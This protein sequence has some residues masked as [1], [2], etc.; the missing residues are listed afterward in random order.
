MAVLV[1]RGHWAAQNHTGTG[2]GVGK[3]AFGSRVPRFIVF[4]DFSGTDPHHCLF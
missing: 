3:L 4:A 1:T 2:S